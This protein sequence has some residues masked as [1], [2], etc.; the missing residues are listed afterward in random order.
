MLECSCGFQDHLGTHWPIEIGYC[1]PD[2]CQ[3]Q[4]CLS[5]QALPRL[6][7]GGKLTDLEIL[8]L[9]CEEL[10]LILGKCQAA[11][12]LIPIPSLEIGHQWIPSDIAILLLRKAKDG[13]HDYLTLHPEAFNDG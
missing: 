3:C 9:K 13:I 1:C 12:E 8:Q 10:E 5:W 4:R 2:G 11:F 6:E 7:V